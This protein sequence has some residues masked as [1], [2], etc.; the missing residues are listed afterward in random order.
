MSYSR[1]PSAAGLAPKSATEME[2]RLSAM[3]PLIPSRHRQR[4]CRLQSYGA[5]DASSNLLQGRPS[6]PAAWPWRIS[7]TLPPGNSF[8]LNKAPTPN[9]RWYV[10]RYTPGPPATLEIST[11]KL[12]AHPTI[13]S[14]HTYTHATLTCYTGNS[15]TFNN[16]SRQH[17]QM[18]PSH[19]TILK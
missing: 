4:S 14:A 19:T 10:S 8:L 15:T 17:S 11:N 2:G 9:I 3:T 16:V 5:P 7:F 18:P 13:P 6:A 12:T 1:R